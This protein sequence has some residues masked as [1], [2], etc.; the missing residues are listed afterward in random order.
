M[1]DPLYFALHYCEG[2]LP[3]NVSHVKVRFDHKQPP[4]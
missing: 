2:K 1:N 3:Q 4:G